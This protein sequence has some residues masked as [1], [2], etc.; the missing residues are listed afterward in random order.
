MEIFK[1]LTREKK[2]A[3][4]LHKQLRARNGKML[5]QVLHQNTVSILLQ[6]L[7]NE[8]HYRRRLSENSIPVT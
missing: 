7:G 6:H 4:F 5:V 3:T 1:G 8:L 2:T